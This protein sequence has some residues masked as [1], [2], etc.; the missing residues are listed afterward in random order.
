MQ[1]VTA[2][3]ALHDRKQNYYEFVV[4]QEVRQLLWM[5]MTFTF[6]A[7]RAS[8]LAGGGDM[9]LVA[10]DVMLPRAGGLIFAVFCSSVLWERSTLLAGDA[11]PLEPFRGVEGVSPTGALL[12]PTESWSRERKPQVAVMLLWSCRSDLLHQTWLLKCER[13]LVFMLL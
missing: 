6:L 4:R 12:G 3:V 5:G 8:F 10:S 1:F 13:I 7:D 11:R 9:V 2:G